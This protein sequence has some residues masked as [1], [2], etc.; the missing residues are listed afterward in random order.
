MTLCLGAFLGLNLLSL[1]VS[2]YVHGTLTALLD[3]AALFGAYLLLAHGGGGRRAVDWV[4]GAVMLAG[5][6][7]VAASL[8]LTAV[9]LLYWAEHKPLGIMGH[10]DQGQFFD[11]VIMPLTPA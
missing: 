4:L 8:G 7:T 10:N 9:D 5:L 1:V 11:G 3:L 6:L 2:I